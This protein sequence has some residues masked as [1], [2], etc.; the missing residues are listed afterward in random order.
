MA[1]RPYR[2]FTDDE[3]D[4]FFEGVDK[5]GYGNWKQIKEDPDFNERLATRSTT[6]LKDKGRNI[7]AEIVTAKQK[8]SPTKTIGSKTEQ[9]SKGEGDFSNFFWIF[10]LF[11]ILLEV[12][13]RD[14]LESLKLV[15]FL[16]L[17]TSLLL[18]V[19][20]SRHA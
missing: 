6:N 14:M 1:T 18:W 12:T 11:F 15:C 10:E 19:L 2:K 13:Q 3:T 7:L 9:I 8:K 5:H 16:F 20:I 4:A 17:V